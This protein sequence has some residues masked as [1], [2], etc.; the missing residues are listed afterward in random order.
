MSIYEGFIETPSIEVE[1]EFL[2]LWLREKLIQNQEFVHEGGFLVSLND[3][4][5]DYLGMFKT[6]AEFELEEDEIALT[7]VHILLEII[8]DI[9]DN[10]ILHNYDTCHILGF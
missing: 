3:L 10:Y 7:E 1:D 5:Y 6:Y 4:R 8:L 2:W 9:V